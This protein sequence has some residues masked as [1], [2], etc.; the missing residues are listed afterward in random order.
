MQTYSLDLQ[1]AIMSYLTS[2]T[3][4]ISLD[5]AVKGT[6]YKKGFICGHRKFGRIWGNSI[7][8]ND[9][10]VPALLLFSSGLQFNLY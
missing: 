6:K 2:E 8:F 9:F 4:V 10:R 5:T 3:S 1:N 7:N